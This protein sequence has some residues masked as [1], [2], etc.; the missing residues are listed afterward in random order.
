MDQ[1]EG[2]L[3]HAQSDLEH[4][5]YDWAC[6]SS[7][8]AAE[9]AAKAVFQKLGAEAWGHSVA[10]LL[11]ELSRTQPVPEDLLNGA[12]ELDKAYIP[13]RYPNAHPTGSPRER[14][15]QEEARRLIRHAENIVKF[16]AS[17]LS[18]IS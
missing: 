3:R 5:F 1:A 11:K 9:K 16:C 12:Y 15:I 7:Q 14:Y 17:L 6:F 13:A 2:D 18:K 10:D 8:Q 4:G